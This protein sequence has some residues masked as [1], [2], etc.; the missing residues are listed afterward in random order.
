MCLEVEI[1]HMRN[2]TASSVTN[3]GYFRIKLIVNNILYAI[4]FWKRNSSCAVS[5]YTTH[6]VMLQGIVTIWF[7]IVTI[8]LL[9]QK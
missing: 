7:V 1:V 6:T 8:A 2:F 9:L 3:E 5:R 4:R